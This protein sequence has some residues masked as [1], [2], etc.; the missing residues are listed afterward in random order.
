MCALILS[1]FHIVTTLDKDGVGLMLLCNFTGFA[2]T[3]FFSSNVIIISGD[4]GS[5]VVINDYMKERVYM[6]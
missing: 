5:C 3:A 4:G 2:G 1:T 6:S